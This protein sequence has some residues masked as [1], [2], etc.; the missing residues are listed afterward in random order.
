MDKYELVLDLIEHPDR[1][2]PELLEQL[3]ADCE[4]REI[5]KALCLADSAVEAGR[6][7]DT[8]A[9]WGAF[10]PKLAARPRRRAFAWFGSRAASVAAVV[11]TSVVALA[12]GIAFAV[13][14]VGRKAATET[15]RVAKAEAAAHVRQAPA[16]VAD[17]DST[18]VPVDTAQAVPAPVM[19]EDATLETIMQAVAARYGV[20]VRF[21]SKEV[22]A[23]H[24]YYR[25]DPALP[26]DAIVSQLNTF[27]Q[28]R[29]TRSGQTLTID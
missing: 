17:S 6:A 23:L 15:A 9:E 26:L 28:I 19:F 7:I 5:Y 22:A 25:F 3:L 20:R 10:S 4:A 11:C 16:A 2:A 12:A 24:L 18:A 21:G 1:Y 8:E 13:S 29:I 14:S 27:R